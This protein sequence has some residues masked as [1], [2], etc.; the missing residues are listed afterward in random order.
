MGLDT[1]HDCWHGSYGSF[2]RW[3]AKVC[4]VSGYGNLMERHGFGTLDKKGVI[5]WPDD[6]HLVLLLYHSDCDGEIRARDCELIAERLKSLL[7]AMKVAGPWYYDATE[8]WISGLLQASN[9]KISASLYVQW[10]KEKK[11]PK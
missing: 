3:R 6:D 8:R 1:T 5:P 4:E 10:L 9:L 7:P 2:N 11:L